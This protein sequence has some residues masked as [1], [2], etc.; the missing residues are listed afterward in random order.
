VN[1]QITAA[2]ERNAAEAREFLKGMIRFEST[3]GNEAGVVEFCRDGFGKAGCECELVPV[4]EEIT[5]DPEYSFADQPVTY[6]GRGSVVAWRRG[7]GGGRSVI[8]QAHL[9]VVPAGDWED[10]FVPV[11]EGDFVIGRGAAD[12]KGQVAAIWLAMKALDELGV[13]LAGDVQCQAVIEE[14]NGGNGALSLIRGGYRADAV[15]VLESSELNIHPAN[16]GAIWFK[17]EVEG[18][19]THMGRKSE[20]I[21]AIDLS[22][23]VVQALCEYEK[24]IIADSAHYPGFER[25]ASPVQVNV[26]MLSAGSWPAQVAASAVIEGGVGFLPN[27]SMEQVKREVKDVIDAIDDPWL[28][29]H[30]KLSFPKLH[31]DSYEIDYS[32]PA[33]LALQKAAR[34]SGLN[35]E[36]FGWNVSCDAR[37]YAKVGGMPTIVFGPGSVAQAHARGEKIKF[38]EV[39]KAAEAVVRFAIEWCGGSG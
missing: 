27:R 13:T 9:D 36:V 6:Q 3:P 18:L 15:V 24:L 12:D 31:N 14:E 35:S 29:E 22:F 37:L 5:S 21:S 2:V 20:G 32:H 33:V 4:P 17:I 8:L 11:D 19:P 38:G 25:Y 34:E 30:Y 28:R 10:A 26:G 23:K 1:D 16:R 39:A 7:S